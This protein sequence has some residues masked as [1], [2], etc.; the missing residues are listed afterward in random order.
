MKV[1]S[2]RVRDCNWKYLHVVY[3]RIKDMEGNFTTEEDLFGDLFFR[4]GEKICSRLR[5]RLTCGR[6]IYLSNFNP[7][8]ASIFISRALSSASMTKLARNV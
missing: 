4:A 1:I 7:Y 8:K 2:Q 6:E 5:M 3:V